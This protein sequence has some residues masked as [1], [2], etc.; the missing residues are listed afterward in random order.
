MDLSKLRS[1]E[2][3]Q[4]VLADLERALERAAGRCPGRP[5]QVMEVCG[6]HT[7]AIASSGMRS[8]LPRGLRMLSG[9]GCPV[10]VTAAGDIDRA[11]AVAGQPNTIVAT[12]GDMLKVPG[13]RGSLQQL[14]GAGA[15]VQVVYSPLEAVETARRNPETRVVFLGVG[16]ETTAP[17]VAA[18]AHRA[19]TEGLRNFLV[20][21]MFKLV[22]PA[23]HAILSQPDHRID[24]LLLPGHV[25]VIVGTDSYRFVAERYRIPSVVAGFEPLDILQALDM[26]LRQLG[27]GEASVQNQYRRTVRSEGN[28]RALA[29]LEE[30]FEPIDAAWRAVGVIPGSGLGFREKYRVLDAGALFDLPVVDLPEPAGCLCGNILMGRAL[31]ADCP[32]FGQVCTPTAPVGPC[33]VSSEGACAAAYKYGEAAPS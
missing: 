7:M 8:M 4:G 10:C 32:L 15:R 21:P 30:M 17:I 20:L 31:P 13:S 3:A 26:L 18:A 25:A 27:S 12:F 6:T 2:L 23:L 5:V 19:W 28:A 14:K 24:G 9:P 1:E 11:L 33:M 16:F 29:L 22:P